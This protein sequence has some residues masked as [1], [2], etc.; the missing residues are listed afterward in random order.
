MPSCE[1]A[2]WPGRLISTN[3]QPI[4][5][6]RYD[7]HTLRFA[8]GGPTKHGGEWIQYVARPPDRSNTAPVLNEH[9]SEQSHAIIAAASPTS[10][11]RAIGI[12]LSMKPMCSG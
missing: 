5:N 10:R 12:L 8:A 11:K 9:S 4:G 1:T 7:K 2:P 3:A 6:R